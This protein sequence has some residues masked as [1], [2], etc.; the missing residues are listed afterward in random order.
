MIF[1]GCC[2]GEIMKLRSALLGGA[3]LL[4]S[5]QVSTAQSFNQF[6]AFGDSSIDSGWWKV[7]L[8]SGQSTG[9]PG[10]DKVLKAAIANGTSGQPVGAGN[11]MS[12]QVLASF[13]GLTANPANQPG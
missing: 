10:K 13:F 8:G 3:A 2:W 6:F 11:S 5:T 1:R 7:W 12:S 4:L 9:N